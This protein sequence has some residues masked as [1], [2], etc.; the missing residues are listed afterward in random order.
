MGGGGGEGYFVDL[1]RKRLGGKLWY[2]MKIRRMTDI[3][4]Q[5]RS[6]TMPRNV[7]AGLA[8]PPSFKRFEGMSNCG[9][10]GEF[11]RP[12]RTSSSSRDA[13]EN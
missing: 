3:L 2:I 12:L 13:G 6:W 9:S 11:G 5:W 4:V 8:S 7:W 1:E 10:R